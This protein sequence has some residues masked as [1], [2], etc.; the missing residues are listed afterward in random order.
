MKKRLLS[1]VLSLCMALSLLP[2]TV[3]AVATPLGSGGL[4]ID[5]GESG[6]DYTYADSVLTILTETALTLSGTSTSDRIEVGSTVTAHLTFD[7]LSMK[8]AA[9]AS[10]SN[11]LLTVNSGA[12]LNLVLLGEN[13]LWSKGSDHYNTAVAVESEGTLHISGNGSLD[14]VAQNYGIKCEDATVNITGGT[15]TAKAT[16]SNVSATAIG[17]DHCTVS[18]RGDDTSVN[19]YGGSIGIGN[20]IAGSTPYVWRKAYHH[21]R[22][23]GQRLGWLYF[24]G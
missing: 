17:G 5:G 15:V 20:G 22:R 9:D 2:T 21:G 1:L 8:R 10:S 11:A 23:N 19:A 18:I 7:G 24:W 12:T 4:S 14:V 13:Y 3:W 16:Q 6:R